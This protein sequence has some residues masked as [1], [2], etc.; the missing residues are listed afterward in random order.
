M[1]NTVKHTFS[2]IGDRGSDLAR[3]LG[4]GTAGIARRVGDG[5][6]TLVRRIGPRNALIGLAVAAV[7]IGG[8]IVVI[9]YLRAR[10]AGPHITDAGDSLGASNA[11]R[12]SHGQRS[13]DVQASH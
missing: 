6:V 10:N 1:M 3:T 13:A 2:S 9:R 8:S 12:R 4:S 7:A 5:S 11:S